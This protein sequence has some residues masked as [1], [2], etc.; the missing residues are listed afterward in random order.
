[1]AGQSFFARAKA[2]G[3]IVFTNAMRVAGNNDQF[4]KP[5]KTAKIAELEKHRLWLDLSN[6]D[7]LFKQMLVGYVEGATNN[8]DDRFD[9]LSCNEHRYSECYSLINDS[10]LVI[11][12]RAMAFEDTDVVA[13]GYR[14][15]IAGKFKIGINHADGDLE[16]HAIYLVDKVT[17]ITH[18]L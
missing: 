16:N 14:S 1:A 3:T 8:Y 15:T 6:N 7:G 10:E 12:G 9:G 11:Q 18:D 5:G 17:Q 4:F 13:V 2:E